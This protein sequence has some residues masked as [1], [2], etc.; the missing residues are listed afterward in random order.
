MVAPALES[1]RH[2]CLHFHPHISYVFIVRELFAEEMLM[3]VLNKEPTTVRP[4]GPHL[5]HPQ[6]A[7][8]I[9]HEAELVISA[10][11]TGQHHGWQE[12]RCCAR[13]SY[14]VG[15][16]L[17]LFSDMS[18]AAPWTLY[19]RDANARGLGF[20]TPHRLPLGHGGILEIVVPEGAMRSIPCTLLRC[21][22]AAPGWYEGSL[23]FNRP[24]L[25][26]SM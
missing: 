20:I 21:R 23:Y 10:I 6:A 16:H 13:A 11:E 26:F 24:Q 1:L 18:D 14:R 15:A 3:M 19:S 2:P 17:R 9:P 7:P 4:K 25:D 12:R 5:N 8:P 22:E